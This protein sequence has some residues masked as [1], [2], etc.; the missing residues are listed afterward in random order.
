MSYLVFE[1]GARIPGT[2]DLKQSGSYADHAR[3]IGQKPR[4]KDGRYRL[5]VLDTHGESQRPIMP[6]EYPAPCRF[7]CPCKK[8]SGRKETPCM[9]EDP[10]RAG[11]RVIVTC[12]PRE[13]RAQIVKA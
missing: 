11:T 6:N 4:K 12:Y 3:S 8:A 9:T 5:V 1:C 7:D 2:G 13:V 10:S